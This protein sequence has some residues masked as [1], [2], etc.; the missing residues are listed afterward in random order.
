MQIKRDN[1][2]VASAIFL[3]LI[4]LTGCDRSESTIESESGQ[5][6]IEAVKVSVITME[7]TP[8]R[9]IVVLPGETEAW[10][11]VRLASDTDGVVETLGPEEGQEVKK[12]ELIAKI[13]VSALKAALDRA[14]ASFKLADELY[15][16]RNMLFERQVIAA[17][18]LDRSRTERA[19][20]LST[21]Q[22]A[23]V[24]YERGFVYSP[25]K[26][27]VNHLHV[28]V[29]EYAA[30]GAP[31]ADLVNVE[32]IKIN[33]NVPEMDVHYLRVGQ[34]AVVRVDA[35]PDRRLV[36]TIDFVAYK[37]DPATKTF[38]ARVLI[39]N[40]ERDIRPGMIARVAFL[41]R[42]VPNAVVAPLS[43][44]VD[45]GGERI[46]FVEKD[47]VA[48]ARTVSIGVLEGDRVQITSGLEP[49]DD[50]IV[51]GQ[52]EVEEGTRVVASVAEVDRKLDIQLP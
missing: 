32:K 8:I 43:A 46:V 37:A 25:V 31:V 17:E 13:Q 45:K 38:Q 27:V 21:L 7:P 39:D 4:F 16:R 22:Q 14:E 19:L 35:L 36:G 18:E 33:V 28:D 11:D 6:K 12:G 3:L 30:R 40:L 29:G 50:L 48:H 42:I 2:Y 9:D 10:Q 34:E 20:A 51:T 49:G 15:E 24:E 1:L 41:R 44:L 47:G 52:T 26:G 5:S 23:R